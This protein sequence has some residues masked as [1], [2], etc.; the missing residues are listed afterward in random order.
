MYL[1]TRPKRKESR[2]AAGKRQRWRRQPVQSK[3]TSRQRYRQ[4]AKQEERR[5]K[6]SG[7]R[8]RTLR[9]RWWREGDRVR[10]RR[11][12]IAGR[13][14]Q[15]QCRWRRAP[16]KKSKRRPSYRTPGRR[17]IV[18]STSTCRFGHE[19]AAR[20]DRPVPSL[21]G[22]LRA[23]DQSRRQGGI[24]RRLKLQDSVFSLTSGAA[25]RARSVLED[26]EAPTR[27]LI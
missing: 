3:R 1:S 14:M 27:R 11:G 23:I 10:G 13:D 19:C 8:R 20:R 12:A 18:E 2:P 21:Q 24:R 16:P 9:G 17:A 4:R 5:K 26:D 22:H 25:S 7:A 6:A 15:K